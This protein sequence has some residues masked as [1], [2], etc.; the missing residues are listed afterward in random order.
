VIDQAV[1]IIISRSAGT[2][3]EAFAALRTI[4]QNEHT[5]LAVVAQRLVDEAAAPAPAHSV[6]K[7]AVVL[8]GPFIAQVPVEIRM[9][10]STAP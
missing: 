3:T 8:A 9:F 6:P 5:K 7:V 10:A 1:G 4:S 2:A